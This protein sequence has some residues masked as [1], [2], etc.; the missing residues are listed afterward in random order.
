LNYLLS[1]PAFAGLYLLTALQWHVPHTVAL[2]YVLM[3]LLCFATHAWDKHA[4]R[5]GG[6]RIRERTLLAM[7]LLCGWPGAILA[8][9]MLRHKSAK[10]SFQIPFW[11]TVVLNIA[12]FVVLNS[13]Q[14]KGLGS[15]L[16]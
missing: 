13:P 14:F 3:S 4:A 9:H 5:S 11:T 6:R 16:G 2:A 12:G 1:I 15:L 7:G 10:P 8:Q